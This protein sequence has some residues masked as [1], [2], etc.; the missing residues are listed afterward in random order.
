MCSQSRLTCLIDPSSGP[1]KQTTHVRAGPKITIRYQP[2]TGTQEPRCSLNT[3]AC[4]TVFFSCLRTVPSEDLCCSVN[5]GCGC[6]GHF[7]H[8]M[9]VTWAARSRARDRGCANIHNKE[10]KRQFLQQGHR[11]AKPESLDFLMSLNHEPG[12]TTT[13]KNLNLDNFICINFCYKNSV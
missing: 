3:T 8:M 10:A 4:D 12:A 11:P 6:C 7:L 9:P 13:Y 1:H 2:T 5:V